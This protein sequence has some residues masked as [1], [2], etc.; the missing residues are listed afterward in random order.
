MDKSKCGVIYY[1]SGED[2]IKEANKS[3]KSVRSKLKDIPIV[4]FTDG[5]GQEY[6]DEKLF[7]EIILSK[8]GAGYKIEKIEC[9]LHSPFEKTL[10][11]DSDTELLEPVFELFELLDKFD[12]A[13]AHAPVR[14]GGLKKKI[15]LDCFPGVQLWRFG[16]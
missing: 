14:F 3:A 13:A 10:F 12:L 2:Y 15:G 11:L 8:S 16:F 7:D 1:A 4:I 5:N 6:L 9:M